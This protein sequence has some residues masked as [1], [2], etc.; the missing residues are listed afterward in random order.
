[1]KLIDV[2]G[3]RKVIATKAAEKLDFKLAYK[4][5]KLIKLTNDD[6]DFYNKHQRELLEQYSRKDDDGNVIPDENG[7]YQ[8]DN[9]KIAPLNKELKE[10][11]D[12]EV[13]IPENLKF[14]EEELNALKFSIE[15]V[16]SLGDLI[17]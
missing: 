7:R 1:M 10:L 6:E 3:A 12:T 17:I 5:A 11:A 14:P 4:F 8:F 15:E 2:V 9:D 16:L 13:E